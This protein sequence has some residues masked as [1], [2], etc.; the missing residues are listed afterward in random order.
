MIFISHYDSPLGL[1]EIAAGED[2]LKGVWFEGQKYFAAGLKENET[3]E[4]ETPVLKEMR[5]W[6]DLYF[7]GK[8]PGFLPKLAPEGSEFRK[9]VWE[10]LLTI[11]Y[12]KTMT[13]GEIGD[14]VAK[15][16]GK[17]TMS[18]QAV[19]GAV[20]HNPI[21]VLIPCHRVVGTNGSLTGYAGGIERKVAL[22]KLEGADMERLFVPKKGT[23][24]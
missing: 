10:I 7:A 21:S 23:A 18:A 1:I 22:L 2:G 8:E 4:K 3:E 9:M 11:P 24:L 5:E 14:E 16:T 13:Y 19:G 20:G 6:L 15:R 12:G 17:R